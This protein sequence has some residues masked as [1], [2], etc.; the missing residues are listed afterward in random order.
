VANNKEN[1]KIIYQDNIFDLMEYFDLKNKNNNDDI[2][3][4]YL[5]QIN[6][7]NDMSFM[8]YKCSSL[9]SL[10]E[11]S[12]LNSNN[13]T[14]INSIFSGCSSLLKLPDI[15]NWNTKNVSDMKCLFHLMIVFLI[16]I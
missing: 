1:F 6:D 14:K 13:V 9:I 12:R 16:F 8:F 11:L 7:I 4:I 3:E 15:S 10:P 5:K 2:L